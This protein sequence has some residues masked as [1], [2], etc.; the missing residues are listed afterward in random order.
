MAQDPGL[1]DVVLDSWMRNNT[2]TV[3]LLRA[4]KSRIE[5]GR[6]MD[7]HSDHPL[8]FLQHMIWH[9]GY[10]HGQVKLALKLAGRPIANREIGPGTWRVW[11][12]KTAGPRA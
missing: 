1:L 8:L 11:M 3:N 4:V 7:V 10:H 5:S 12:N 9:E 2:I 6:A